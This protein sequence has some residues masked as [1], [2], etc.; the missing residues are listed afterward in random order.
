MFLLVLWGF[1]LSHWL[2]R[3]PWL[4]GE[5]EP[6]D[7]QAGGPLQQV[8]EEDLADRVCQVLHQEWGRGED[9]HEGL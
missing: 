3:Y 7:E 6:G 2:P 8:R 5:G 4:R 9:L 1:E